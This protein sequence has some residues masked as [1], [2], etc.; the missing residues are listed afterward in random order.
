MSNKKGKE[1]AFTNH[2]TKQRS[3]RLSQIIS[4]FSTSQIASSPLVEGVQSTYSHP[5]PMNERPNLAST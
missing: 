3:K 2:P 5:P 1:V 4:L